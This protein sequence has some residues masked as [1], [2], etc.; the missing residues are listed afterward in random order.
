LLPAFNTQKL[1]FLNV[2]LYQNNY[3]YS[4]NFMKLLFTHSYFL[5]FDP[6]QV[7]HSQ[8]YPPLGTLFAASL[9]RENKYE[10]KLFDTMFANHP[11]E[12][13]PVLENF[14]PD[15]LIV[16]DDGFNYL[17]KMCL[18]NMREAAFKMQAH[19]KAR[20]CK[21]IVT[22][23]D[24]ADHAEKYLTNGADFV[25]VGE[26]EYTLLELIT[27]FQNNYDFKQI[28]G[29]VYKDSD[30][31]TTTPKRSVSKTLNELP[32]PAWDLVTIEPYKKVW[33]NK[34]GYFSL[35][36]ATTRGCP[37]HC[38]WCAKP[39]YGNSYN[40]RSPENVVKELKLLKEKFK[41]DHIW[42]CD[43]IFGLKRSWVSDFS[44]LIKKEKIQIKYKIQS[45]A[46]LLVQEK[47]V[48]ALAASGCDDVW[49]GAE[50]G[51]QKIL[52][53]MDKGTTIQEIKRARQLLKE[54]DIKASFFLQYGYSGETKED[55]LKTIELIKETMPDDIGISVSYPLPGTLFYENVKKD[56]KEKTNWTDSD[57]LALMFKNTFS[58]SYYKTLHRYT[59]SIYRKNKAL[60]RLKE[61]LTISSKFKPFYQFIKYSIKAGLQSYRLNKTV[62]THG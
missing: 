53:A 50:S 56:L 15:V 41:V 8:P 7:A 13:L 59:H 6:K 2:W 14:Q 39:I 4:V 37:Y 58:P 26:A 27:G 40:M 1:P 29:I 36:I 10:V 57:E 48:E 60:L 55:I 22:S 20:Q 30:K 23:S 18:S 9:M 34:H 11:D 21:V 46:D 31:I 54:Y 3:I 28:K 16:Y 45:R 33:M 12:I 51:S 43:D 47:Y 49:M 44:E 61:S 17:T 52:D 35:N 42:F 19:A 62:Q 24:A 38:N 32:L 25:I 5:Q